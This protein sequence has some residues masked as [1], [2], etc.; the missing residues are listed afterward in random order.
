MILETVVPIA[1]FG[2][3]LVL[4]P[5]SEALAKFVRKCVWIQ[6]VGVVS[7]LTPKPQLGHGRMTFEAG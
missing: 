5:L 1:I 3:T 7:V 6:P 4:I 2:A